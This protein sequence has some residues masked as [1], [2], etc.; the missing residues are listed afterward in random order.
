M[1]KLLKGLKEPQSRTVFLIRHGETALNA[2]KKIRAWSDV[3]LNEDGFEQAR[4]LGKKLKGS[5]IDMLISSDLT[6][7]LQTSS[8]I[9]EES[10][11]PLVHTSIAL[12]PLNVGKYTAEDQDKVLEI[13]KNF[14]N[15]K[16]DETIPEG[17][18]FASFKYRCLMGIIGFLNQYR[19][20]NICFVSHHRNDRLLRSWI[21]NGCPSDLSLDLDHFFDYGIEPGEI[22][23]FEITSTYLL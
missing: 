16:P 18:S 17:E 9:S 22:D 5:S 6:R 1:D 15:D 10:G 3:P 8:L 19:D 12:R 14:V 4:N 11:I 13:I 2:E 21:E 20:K 23:E 7:T